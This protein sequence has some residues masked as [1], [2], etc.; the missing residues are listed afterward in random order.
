MAG[1]CPGR[2]TAS[3]S[4]SASSAGSR[5]SNIRVDAEFATGDLAGQGGAT[6]SI[7][8]Q[9]TVTE[10]YAE[11]RV[12]ILQRQPWAYDLSVNGSYRYSNYSTDKTTNSYGIGADWAPIKEAK[13]RGSY[14]QAVRAAN[15]IELFLGTGFN[16][17]DGARSLRRSHADRHAGAMR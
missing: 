16:L 17:F 4:R 6:L 2:R 13:M 15:I 12:P 1:R 7:N 14:Q 3:A 9:Y 8:G 11:F 10:P 5:S